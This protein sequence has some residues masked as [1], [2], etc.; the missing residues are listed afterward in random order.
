MVNIVNIFLSS[1]EYGVPVIAD[2]GIKNTGCLIKSLALGASSVILGSLLA[3]V[4]ECPG[5]YFYQVFLWEL[6]PE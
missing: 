5:A 1:S 4:N 6:N 3:G 2:G